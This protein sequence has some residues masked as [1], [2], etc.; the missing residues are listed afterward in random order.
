VKDDLLIARLKDIT[1]RNEAEALA[2]VQ[3]YVMRAGLPPPQ[4][5]EFYFAD[6]IGL[7]AYGASGE[8]IG[9][10]RNVLNYGAGDMLEIAPGAAGET[11]LIPFTKEAV[12]VVDVTGGRL[13]VVPP[14]EIELPPEPDEDAELTPE[15]GRDH[16]A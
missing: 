13:V 12:P 8:I 6:L 7:A 1:T 4:E 16:T 9:Q 5:D 10:V 14:A 11:L 2:G 15:V 3:V